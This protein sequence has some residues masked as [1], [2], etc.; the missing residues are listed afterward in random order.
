[1]EWDVVRFPNCIV[2]QSR[3]WGPW[4]N[5][6]GCALVTILFNIRVTTHGIGNWNTQKQIKVSSIIQITRISLTFDN[7]EKLPRLAST[8]VD[9]WG[10]PSLCPAPAHVG[11]KRGEEGE[12]RGQVLMLILWL[13]TIWRTL[14]RMDIHTVWVIVRI[15]RGWILGQLVNVGKGNK[16]INWD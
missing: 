10:H 6:M 3:G 11:G 7:S 9:V 8:W 4:L 2:Y 16:G 5:G 15:D 13:A 14:T 1:M 12:G